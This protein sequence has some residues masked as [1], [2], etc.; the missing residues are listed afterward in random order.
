MRAQAGFTYIE[1]MLV[2]GIT[3]VLMGISSIILTQ[4]VPHASVMTVAQTLASELRSQQLFAMMGRDL[5]GG[6]TAFGVY[7][8]PSSYVLFEGSTYN[9]A[10]SNNIVIN[11]ES[12]L[13]L[14]STLTSNQVVFSPRSGEVAS[15]AS[16][17]DTITLRQVQSGETVTLLV[18][19]L[20][21]VRQL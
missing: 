17:Q 5:Q 21:V 2:V 10:D 14:I 4:L 7:F 19:Q 9:V 12:G 1:T 18:N 20:G 11:L 15:Y 3:I 6:T 13:E 8:T 16:G